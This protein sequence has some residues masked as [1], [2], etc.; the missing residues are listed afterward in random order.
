[1]TLTCQQL[2]KHPLVGRNT[3]H[4]WLLELFL[5]TLF[6]I[7]ASKINLSACLIR[8]DSSDGREADCKHGGPGFESRR[9]QVETNFQS[10]FQ[11]YCFCTFM[12]EDQ[13]NS[14]DNIVSNW[15]QYFI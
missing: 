3:Q 7:F 9:F 6:Q 15:K 1:M 10:Y 12:S 4:I 13:A 8:L 11:K 5:L 2:A 14:C